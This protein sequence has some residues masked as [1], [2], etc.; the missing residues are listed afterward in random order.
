[1]YLSRQ[2]REEWEMQSALRRSQDT[3]R[4]SG[5]VYRSR[6]GSFGKKTTI[7]NLRKIEA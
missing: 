2:A 5:G 6:W 1:M 7:S 3:L 4:P